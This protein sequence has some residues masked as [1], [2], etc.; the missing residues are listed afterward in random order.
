[1]NSGSLPTTFGSSAPGGFSAGPLV[2]PA[3]E[4]RGP[5]KPT[6]KFEQPRRKF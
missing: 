5:A 2:T 1:L 6:L 3:P 4:A